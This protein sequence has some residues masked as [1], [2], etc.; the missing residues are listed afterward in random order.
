MVWTFAQIRGIPLQ[1][2]ISMLILLPMIAVGLGGEHL[3]GLI[4]AL[5]RSPSEL[6]FPPL[7]YGTLITF[8][9]FL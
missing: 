9:L 6:T 7:V 1:L 5:G 2:H 4:T 8:G 3:F